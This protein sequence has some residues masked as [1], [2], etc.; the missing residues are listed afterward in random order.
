MEQ[1][2]AR[3]EEAVKHLADK[4]DVVRLESRIDAMGD[5]LA[6]K[7]DGLPTFMN[8]IVIV[9]LMGVLSFSAALAPKVYE[10][11]FSGQV[12]HVGAND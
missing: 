11:W 12:A 8:V 4:S 3:L 5:K 7:I 10:Y 6:A 9:G 1:R 2:V